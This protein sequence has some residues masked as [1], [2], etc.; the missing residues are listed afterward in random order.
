MASKHVLP[1]KTGLR[2]HHA[3][4]VGRALRV[5][6]LGDDPTLFSGNEAIYGAPVALDHLVGPRSAASHL[7]ARAR[8][9]DVLVVSLTCEDARQVLKKVAA[10]RAGPPIL[11]LVPPGGRAGSMERDMTLAELDGA[12]L[13]LPGPVEPEEVARAVVQLACCHVDTP[14]VSGRR[15]RLRRRA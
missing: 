12:T 8:T 4:G 14:P 9:A 15:I 5:A 13:V 2:H 11:A 3:R 10:E 1:G 6:Y 7:S